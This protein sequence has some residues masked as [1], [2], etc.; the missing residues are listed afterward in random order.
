[1]K[2]VKNFAGQI[3]AMGILSLLAV[4]GYLYFAVFPAVAIMQQA[5]QDATV[6]EK[7]QMLFAEQMLLNNLL[8]GLAIVLIPF[9]VLLLLVKLRRDFVLPLSEMATFA[10]KLGAGEFPP[11]LPLPETGSDLTGLTRSLNLQR[12]RLQSTIIKLRACHERE[13]DNR[14]A[15]DTDNA[16]RTDFIAQLAAEL[17][18]PL[19]SIAGFN[20]II[21]NDISKGCYDR[22]LAT[23]NDALG[24]C[25]N[26]L[27][28][29]IARLIDINKLDVAGN[30]INIQAFSTVQFLEQLVEYNSFCVN[31]DELE[32]VSHTRS[33]TPAK[34][35][36]DEHQL[37]AILGLLIRS[38]TRVAGP[39]EVISIECY[40]KQ[41]EI[42]LSCRDNRR[43][44]SR[45]QLA[46]LYNLGMDFY[47]KQG[48]IPID[49]I[50]YS[51]L[52]AARKTEQLGGQL[53]AESNEQSQSE[54]RLIFPARHILP[55][56]EL[57]FQSLNTPRS[58]SNLLHTAPDQIRNENEADGEVIS[59]L[60]ILIA[61]NDR[62]SAQ[63]LQS[64]LEADG[65][66]V[67]VICEGPDLKETLQETP[68]QLAII[69]MALPQIDVFHAIGDICSNPN[70][71]HNV[72]ILAI[73]AYLSE[74]DRQRLVMLGVKRCMI[75]PLNYPQLR[76][77]VQH[78]A[79][80]E[81]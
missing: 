54:F 72:P 31:D 43:S 79:I 69:S 25:T 20:E 46:M 61:E 78:M 10:E 47:E 35:A 74:T 68:F 24:R 18:N 57:A 33:E 65:H 73:T 28:R 5:R 37:S 15:A 12:D 23:L 21:R 40:R 62:D 9:A 22:H 67:T 26:T 2:I 3:T 81:I 8:F 49:S 45:E 64:L 59:S 63:V 66:Q 41:D 1:M 7:L 14:Q 51:L 17:R 75:K 29:L 36:T 71:F 55:E 58:A 53:Q 30:A 34:L 56:S 70:R 42:I 4:I 6:F 11:H 13:R 38:L 27:S 19:N 39:Q 77:Q 52:C 44:S 48:K 76:R 16:S 50:S 60:Q 32:I 80:R